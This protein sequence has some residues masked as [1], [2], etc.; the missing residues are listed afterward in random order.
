[1]F[2]KTSILK[3]YSKKLVDTFIEKLPLFNERDF[4]I[5][6]Q[7]FNDMMYPKAF[8]KRGIKIEETDDKVAY[9]TQFVT[10][11]SDNG[12]LD[13]SFGTSALIEIIAI[14]RAVINARIE[15]TDK[16]NE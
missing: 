3:Y 8:S 10:C 13:L 11:L 16:K 1:M 15:Y 4:K 7:T 12:K 5:M 2:D 14:E 6:E 9:F